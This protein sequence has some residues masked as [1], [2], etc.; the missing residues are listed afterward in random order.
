MG[1]KET[2]QLKCFYKIYWIKSTIVKKSSKDELWEGPLFFFTTVSR[3][4]T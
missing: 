1:M 3:P 2:Y 4:V